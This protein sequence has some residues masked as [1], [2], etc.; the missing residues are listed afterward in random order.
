MD[1]KGGACEIYYVQDTD[2]DGKADTAEKLDSQTLAKYEKDVGCKALSDATVEHERV[3]QRHCKNAYAQ[4]PAGAEKFLD[5]P[6]IVAESEYQAWSRQQEMIA[7]A[8]RQIVAKNGCGWQPTEGQKDNPDAIPSL[9]Q[10]KKMEQQGWKA[11]EALEK[12][13]K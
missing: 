10:I 11:V 4:D 13:T 8:I 5:T 3:H 12:G 1:P 2:N 6:E 7:E 9:E